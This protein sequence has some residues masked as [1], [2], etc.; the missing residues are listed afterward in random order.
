MSGL[1]GSLYAFGSFCGACVL[2]VLH[3]T[4]GSYRGFVG[5]RRIR[6]DLV[7]IA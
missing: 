4:V 3:P 5:V 7:P 6:Y 1:Y 2:S